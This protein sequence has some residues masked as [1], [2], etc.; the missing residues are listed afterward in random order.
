MAVCE[1]CGAT[2]GADSG[3]HCGYCGSAFPR[4][5]KLIQSEPTDPMARVIDEA[6][7]VRPHRM[8]VLT[9]DKP[10]GGEAL[11]EFWKFWTGLTAVVFV[12]M[13][14]IANIIPIWLV[15]LGFVVLGV[16]QT[17]KAQRAMRDFLESP[18]LRQ[19]V[20]VVDERHG[21]PQGRRQAGNI[22]YHVTLETPDGERAEYRTDAELIGLVTPGDVGVAFTRDV[23]LLDFVRM[24]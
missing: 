4:M 3:S 19:A 20:R 5:A 2:A 17:K 10:P 13:L 9:L 21:V 23:H 8:N 11:V 12:G 16:K 7:H 15:P 18:L 6:P 24:G 22:V 1:R 14:C